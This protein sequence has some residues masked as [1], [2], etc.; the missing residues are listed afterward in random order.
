MDEEVKQ[1]APCEPPDCGMGL[2]LGQELIEPGMGLLPVR[3]S[4]QLLNVG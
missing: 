2:D 3:S 1:L 4:Q